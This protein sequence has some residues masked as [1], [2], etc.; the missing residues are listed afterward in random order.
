[1]DVG[2]HSTVHVIEVGTFGDV[3]GEETQRGGG[4]LLP[5]AASVGAEKNS[6]G[7]G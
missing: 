4:E 7:S 1:M 6:C 3:G 2:V 5:Y